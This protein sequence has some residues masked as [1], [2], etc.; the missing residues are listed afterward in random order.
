MKKSIL[1]LSMLTIGGSLYAQQEQG[2]VGINT[3]TPKATLEIGVANTNSKSS[4]NEG[5]IIPNLSKDRVANM[6]NPEVSTLIFVKG[7]SYSGSD[8]RV[9]EVIADG[10][11]YFNGTKWVGLKGLPGA[12][13]PKGDKGDTGATGPAGAR[14]PQGV[15]GPKG[16]K[17]DTG[18]AGPA[19][20]RGPQGVAGPKGDKG[21]TGATGPAGARGPQGVAGPKGDKGD[22]GAAGPA[23]A[24]GPQGVAGP[25]GDKGDTG[26]TGPA[27][28]RGPQGVA[29]PKG[30]KG[31]AGATGPAGARGP[32]G[33]SGVVAGARGI[34]YDAQS[35]TVALP[36]GSNNNQVLKWN[37]TAWAP[38]TEATTNIYNANGTLTSER[39]V[40]LNHQ[41]LHL[42]NGITNISD[43]SWF[44]LI[45]NSTNSGGGGVAIHP[46]DFS[47]R[48]ELSATKDGDFRIWT[49]GGDKVY[50]N[51]STG[52][53]GIG[54]ST[55]QR[56]LDILGSARIVGSEGDHLLRIQKNGSSD[57]TDIVKRANGVF[58]ISNNTSNAW[59]GGLSINSEGNVGIGHESPTEKLDVAGKVR[60][61]SLAGSGNKFVLADNNGTLYKGPNINTPV[62]ESNSNMGYVYADN[63]GVLNKAKQVTERVTRN[64]CFTYPSNP[65]EDNNYDIP[66]STPVNIIFGGTITKIINFEHTF[67]AYDDCQDPNEFFG[68][69][70]V[71]T[72][73]N[74]MPYNKKYRIK[75]SNIEFYQW[76]SGIPNSSG[77]RC[78]PATLTKCYRI[79]ADVI[80]TFN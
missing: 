68:I 62:P 40:N 9:S 3:S 34:T 29:G 59:K 66:I 24:R 73:D 13:G 2:R 69:W 53:L 77:T 47:K 32:Q 50:L 60:I 41:K 52:N 48:V 44:P 6:A 51:R 17:G 33:P 8:A 22:T 5:L 16:D 11:Y 37:G 18:A 72:Q 70:Y 78:T 28:A 30:D 61:S 80:K 76:N 19:G 14:G 15:A 55:P 79:T 10:Y 67:Y 57:F 46:N 23:G 36:A 12:T 74:Y 27:G 4:T 1:L 26:A 65:E 39:Y 35:K 20:A 45:V 75:G 63:D 43:G 49:N 31:D 54:T 56:K 42:D 71:G 21:D 64:D 7:T 58:L 38:A 25:K